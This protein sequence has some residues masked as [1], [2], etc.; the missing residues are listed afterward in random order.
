[1]GSFCQ[2]RSAR[3]PSA[4]ARCRRDELDDARAKRD[5]AAEAANRERPAGGGL[6]KG[7]Y[8]FDRRLSISALSAASMRPVRGLYDDHARPGIGDAASLGLDLRTSLPLAGR[9]LD[10]KG[11]EKGRGFHRA[12][13]RKPSPWGFAGREWLTRSGQGYP[14]G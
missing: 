11:K 14:L 6:S 12:Q 8:C 1:M 9:T 2:N 4:Q 13:L 7:Q 3:G 10:A 5:R